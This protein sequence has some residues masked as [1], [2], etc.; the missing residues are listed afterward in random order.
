MGHFKNHDCSAATVSLFAKRKKERK[1]S[2]SDI[3]FKELKRA[4]PM[5]EGTDIKN[6]RH[7]LFSR[8]FRYF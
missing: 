5:P 8:A 1:R 4:L 3:N 2:E 7:S 6:A